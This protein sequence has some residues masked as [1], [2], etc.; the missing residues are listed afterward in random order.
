MTHQEFCYWLNG[1]A[2]LTTLPPS[3]EQWKSIKEHLALTFRKVT[4]PLQYK[5]PDY[6]QAFPLGGRPIVTC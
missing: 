6:G 3:P 4:P 1:Y 5:A 2:E